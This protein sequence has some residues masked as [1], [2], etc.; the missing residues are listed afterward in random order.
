MT[1]NSK[2]PTE[3]PAGEA[4]DAKPPAGRIEF[5]SR[6]NSVWRWAR[7]VLDSTSILLKR[8]DNTDLSL[9]QTAKLPAARGATK[10]APAAAPEEPS[11]ADAKSHGKKRSFDPYNS[12]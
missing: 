7:D 3:A 10:K 9:E 12:R 5:D 6:G 2:K 11:V 1:T 4:P 8:L